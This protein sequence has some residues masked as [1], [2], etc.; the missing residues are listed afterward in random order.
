MMERKKKGGEGGGVGGMVCLSGVGILKWNFHYALK[1][2]KK[3]SISLISHKVISHKV[4][5][6]ANKSQIHS[7]DMVSNAFIDLH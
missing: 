6:L 2:K 5:V 4:P 1:K 7:Q 3:K